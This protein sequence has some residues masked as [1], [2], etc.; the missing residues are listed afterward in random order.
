[1][2]S[3][4]N[5]PTYQ[6]KMLSVNGGDEMKVSHFI[7]DW[8]ITDRDD[9]RKVYALKVGQSHWIYVTDEEIEV[10]RTQ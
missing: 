3:K 5:T 10:T 8:G 1:M 4:S 6:P 7:A 2:N 9:V